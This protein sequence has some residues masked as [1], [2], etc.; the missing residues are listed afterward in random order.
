AGLGLYISREIVRELGGEMW[1]K[2]STLGKGSTFA[3]TIPLAG[4]KK[5]KKIKR[6][7]EPVILPQPK[8]DSAA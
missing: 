3:F 1:I 8:K 6:L 4:T 7:L 2:S 5:A